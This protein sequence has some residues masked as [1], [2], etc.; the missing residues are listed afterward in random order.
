VVKEETA[1]KLSQKLGLK[2]E[3]ISKAVHDAVDKSIHEIL[4][5]VVERSVTIALITTRELILK[6]FAYDS[7]E[8]KISAASTHIVQNLA[9]SLAL[10]T[11]R[12]PLRMQLTNHIKKELK[13][14][15][16]QHSQVSAKEVAEM[17]AGIATEKQLTQGPRTQEEQLMEVVQSCSKE[18]LELGCNLIKS[19]VIEKALVIVMQDKAINEALEKRIRAR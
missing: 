19:A 15:C 11:C 13:L 12:E 18:N 14:A 6:D 2:E 8:T 17:F 7:D 5:P 16:Q 10:V 9:G 3:H 4:T 1:K